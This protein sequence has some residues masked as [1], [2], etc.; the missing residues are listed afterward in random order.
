MKQRIIQSVSDFERLP[1]SLKFISDGYI[2]N[3][4]FIEKFTFLVLF[5]IK[6]ELEDKV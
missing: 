6:R 2:K 4:I 3:Y 1:M 5:C